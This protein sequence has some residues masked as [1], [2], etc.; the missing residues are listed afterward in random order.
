MK[1]LNMRWGYDGGGMA[2]GPV[3]GSA[4]VEIMVREDNDRLCDGEP[5]G[6]CGEHLYL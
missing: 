4:I 6:G 3:E 2:C 1:I 5:Y